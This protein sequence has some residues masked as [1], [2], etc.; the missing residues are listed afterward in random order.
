MKKI[1]F[2]ALAALVLIGVSCQEKESGKVE[3]FKLD[4]TT[5][6]AADGEAGKVEVF[7]KA[8]NVTPTAEVQGDAVQ[9]LSVE[10]LA[11]CISLT[12]TKNE[13]GNDRTGTVVVTPGKLEPVI[14]TLTQPKAVAGALKVGTKTEDG[15]GVIYWVDPSNATVGKAVSLDRT[16][17]LKWSDND[18]SVEGAGSYV[19]GAANTAN[20]IAR[21][22]D[23]YQ[24]ADFCGKLGEGWYLPARDEL[25]QLFD[26]YNGVA[27]DAAGFTAQVPS[28]IS[29][30]EKAARAAFEKMISD[31]EGTAINAAAE[32]ANGD[33]YWTSTAEEDAGEYGAYYVRFGKYDCPSGGVKKNSTTRF[34]RCIKTIGNYVY[35]GEP[36]RLVLSTSEFKLDGPAETKVATVTTLKNGTLGTATVAPATEGGD[37]SWCTA[38]ISGNDINITVTENN[39]GAARSA[40]V[41]VTAN[42]TGGASA[43]AIINV[44]QAAANVEK[45]QVLEVYKEN[46]VAKGIVFWVSDD[47]QKAKVISLKRLAGAKWS[48]EETVTNFEATDNEDGAANTQK[49][50]QK[51][52]TDG[53]TD[54]I[55][56]IAFL[57]SLG[58]G[59]YL[60]AYNELRALAFAYYNITSAGQ[61][62]TK[63]VLS[64]QT[65]EIQDAA[66]AFE[67]LIKD[68]GGDAINAQEPSF[69]GG[70]SVFSST[71]ASSGASAY[72]YRFGKLSNTSGTKTNSTRTFRGV[73]LVSK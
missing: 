8:E 39:T 61:F 27:H 46:D 24:A 59:W 20:L 71:E 54:K 40:V 28:A 70:D 53:I 68:N 60:P 4:K 22:R 37:A 23:V 33:S 49:I 52:Q 45:F 62:D 16:T 66:A 2:F 12:Y 41:T 35:P 34:V 13:T 43:S 11:R 25:V 32:T 31:L 64:E 30:T 6:T 47:G 15:K 42:G 14:L 44:A 36:V 21:D 57:D 50:R 26:I 65:Q 63:K 1:A 17:G 7:F 18:S 29:A 10:V 48:D 73:K 55:P 9:W 56:W 38:V 5:V 51:A 3:S 67:K 72:Y 69:N 19:N 58:E